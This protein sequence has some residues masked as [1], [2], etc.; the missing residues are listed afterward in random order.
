MALSLGEKLRAAREERGITISEVAEQTRI[1]PLYLEAIDRND[2]K[3]LPG[4]IFNKGF[5]RSYAK[6]VGVSEQEALQDYARL[7]AESTP[8]DEVEV[9]AYRPE[10]LTDDRAATSII[11]TI[12]FA[13]IILGLM[14]A[15]V[16]FLVN[17]IRNERSEPPIAANNGPNAG[18]AVSTVVNQPVQVDPTG[19]AP[20]MGNV[21]VEFR[22]LGSNIWL[23]AESDGTKTTPTVSADTPVTFEP[24]ER[25]TLSYSKSLAKA[26]QLSING[27]PIALPES[28]LNPKKGLIEIDINADNLA[29]IWQSASYGGAAAE[30]AP[31]AERQEPEPAAATS[32]PAASPTPTPKPSAKPSGTQTPKPSASNSSTTPASPPTMTGKPPARPAATPGAAKPPANSG[33]E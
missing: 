30:P 11:P 22:S 14:S 7:V 24:K 9:K 1:S 21:R 19:S 16:L 17:Y 28:P 15:G 2:F 29:S 10:V 27:K 13:A 25:L 5:V 33:N 32:T 26:A 31:V 12:I 8:Q 18:N 4:G 20:T 3:T 23:N 6:Y